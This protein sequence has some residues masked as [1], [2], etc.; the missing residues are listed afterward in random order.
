MYHLMSKDVTVDAEVIPAHLASI[1]PTLTD[2]LVPAV[3][4][5]GGSGTSS[6]GAE[7][8]FAIKRGLHFRK[9]TPAGKAG[10]RAPRL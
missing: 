4:G 1:S 3:L 9:R 6:A 5:L 8:S 2:A 7:A 10:R